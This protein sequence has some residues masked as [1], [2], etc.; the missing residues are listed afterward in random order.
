[1]LVAPR[2]NPLLMSLK[3]VLCGMCECMFICVWCADSRHV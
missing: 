1:M 3:L 2:G